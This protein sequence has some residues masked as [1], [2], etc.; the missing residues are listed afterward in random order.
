MLALDNLVQTSTQVLCGW[1]DFHP[2]PAVL[3]SNSRSN[4]ACRRASISVSSTPLSPCA[5]M[6]ATLAVA[7]L[8][9]TGFFCSS[10]SFGLDLSAS[11]GK[12]TPIASATRSAY[13]QDNGPVH[14]YKHR[15][16]HQGWGFRHSHP[17]PSHNEG[18]DPACHY[19]YKTFKAE[20]HQ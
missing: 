5:K 6:A 10:H 17:H 15:G 1:V 14:Q 11:Q 13:G 8:T 4:L 3:Q 12:Y 9:S 18:T 19:R 16:R 7:S 20:A 2:C